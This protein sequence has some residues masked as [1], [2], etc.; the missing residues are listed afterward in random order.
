M[1]NDMMK[2]ERRYYKEKKGG[3]NW[4]EEKMSVR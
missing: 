1:T 2:N 4:M 3:R